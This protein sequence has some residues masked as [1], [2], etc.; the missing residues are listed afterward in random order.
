[1]PVQRFTL[2][3]FTTIMIAAYV[4][5]GHVVAQLVE[6]LCYM[7]KVAGSFLVGVIGIFH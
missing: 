2:L 3:Y 1:M 5:V 6:A 4:L 7:Q